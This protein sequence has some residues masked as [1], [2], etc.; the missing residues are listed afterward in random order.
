MKI[1]VDGDPI[2]YK[3]AAQMQPVHYIVSDYFFDKKKEAL[4][5]CSENELDPSVIEKL[6]CMLPPWMM[7]RKI[8]QAIERLELDL[9]RYY[10]G[11]SE[12]TWSFSHSDNFRNRVDK[13]YKANRPPKPFYVKHIKKAMIEKTNPL[14]YPK[15]EC[16]DVIALAALLDP[17]DSVIVTVDKDLLNVPTNHFNPDAKKAVTTTYEKGLRSFMKQCLTGDTVD[18]IKGVQGIGPK[19]AELILDQVKESSWG[20]TWEGL[21]VCTETFCIENSLNF[22]SKSMKRDGILLD[23]GHFWMKQL[24]ESH[25]PVEKLMNKCS[26]WIK[27]SI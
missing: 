3:V 18:N 2:L 25:P 19:K 10:G 6:E 16:D 15:L 13:E 14:I 26:D 20:T 23:V 17:E 9:I 7:D 24:G 12:I 27:R 11:D 4:A 8:D 1:F 22:C 21:L 5:F